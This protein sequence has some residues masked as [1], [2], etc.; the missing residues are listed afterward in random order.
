MEDRITIAARVR[1]ALLE[2]S[3][4]PSKR[5]SKDTEES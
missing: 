1:A 5:R 3:S 2:K 4:K